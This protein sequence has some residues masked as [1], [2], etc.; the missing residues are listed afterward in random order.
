MHTV[1]LVHINFCF[2]CNVL[3]DLCDVLGF[4]FISFTCSLC[5]FFQ[6][7]ITCTVP[8]NLHL[9]IKTEPVTVGTDATVY[10]WFLVQIHICKQKLDTYRCIRST[11]VTALNQINFG[12]VCSFYICCVSGGSRRGRRSSQAVS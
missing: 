3:R 9:C 10:V 11:E 7:L 12:T 6:I 4:F 2:L 8:T 5:H 1:L